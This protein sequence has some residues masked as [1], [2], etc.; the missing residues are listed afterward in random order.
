M[1]PSPRPAAPP[2]QAAPPGA[3]HSA[4]PSYLAAQVSFP[5]RL[6]ANSG[7]GESLYRAAAQHVGLGQDGCRDLRRYCHAK[8]L[9]WWQWYE[10]YYV[11]P[12]QVTVV[13]CLDTS[14]SR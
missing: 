4:L 14:L 13:S 6:E 9:E 3:Q 10:P 1:V 5:C 7:G 12:L 2:R 8:L 11:F